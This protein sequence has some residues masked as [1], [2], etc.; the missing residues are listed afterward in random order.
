[1]IRAALINAWRR[2]FPH[3]AAITRRDES[4]R[5]SKAAKARADRDR[6]IALEKLPMLRT[7]IAKERAGA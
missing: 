6:Q 7:S 2:H 1:M 4:E 5:A 3:H